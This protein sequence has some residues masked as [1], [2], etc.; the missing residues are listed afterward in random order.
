M[1]LVFGGD[2]DPNTVCFVNAL[3]QAKAKF[4]WVKLTQKQVPLIALDNDKG[5]L[6]INNQL[7]KPKAFFGRDDVFQS[8][9][10]GVSPAFYETLKSYCLVNDIPMFNGAYIGFHKVRN[11][12]L[13]KR[14]GLS[15][16]K[17]IMTNELVSLKQLDKDFAIKPINGGAYTN[18]LSQVSDL[19]LQTNVVPYFAQTL[20]VGPEIRVFVIGNQLHAFEIRSESLD[21]RTDANTEVI[22][23]IVPQHLAEPLL[24]LCQYLHLD[25]AAADFKTH[26]ITRDLLFL[27]VNSGPMFARFDQASNGALT[28]DMIRWLEGT[29]K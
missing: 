13:A 10:P 12:L 7:I 26:P 19:K 20:L 22:P 6:L 8:T 24:Q 9:Q 25:F 16:P 17:T 21:Y 3:L 18:L 14:Y 28:A 5:D 23:T 15:T 11:L 1:I 4:Y 27:E 2:R 29:G